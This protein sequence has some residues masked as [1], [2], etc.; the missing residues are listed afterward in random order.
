[1]SSRQLLEIA[2]IL[3]VF[4][5]RQ[6]LIGPADASS[7]DPRRVRRRGWRGRYQGSGFRVQGAGF[8]VQGPGFRVRGSGFGVQG[9]RVQGPHAP[10]VVDCDF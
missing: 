10:E 5:L 8:R 6:L 2:E 7:G 3:S 1:V 4:L 9:F